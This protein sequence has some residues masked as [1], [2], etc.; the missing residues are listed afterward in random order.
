[1]IVYAEYIVIF[2]E[3]LISLQIGSNYRN[4]AKASQYIYRILYASSSLLL[5]Y[6]PSPYATEKQPSNKQKKNKL[7][8]SLCC[9]ICQYKK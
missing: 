3:V 6:P 5:F 2:L 4:T 7:G 9:I 8:A 1:M